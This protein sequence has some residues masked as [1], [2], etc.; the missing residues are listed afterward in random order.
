MVEKYNNF[1][2]HNMK[3][4]FI[5]SL[6]LIG[7]SFYNYLLYHTLVEFISISVGIALF[8]VVFMFKI[9]FENS[10][11]P[12]IAVGYF[13][14]SMVDLLH[15]FAYKGMNILPMAGGSANLATQLWIEARFLQALILV[16][17][18]SLISQNISEKKLLAGLG[19]IFGVIT[20]LVFSGYAPDAYIDTYGLTTFKIVMEYIIIAILCFALFRFYTHRELIGEKTTVILSISIVLT[21]FSE[22]SFTFYISVFGI[23]NLIGHIFKFLAFWFILIEVKD[24]IKS[25]L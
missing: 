22:L 7:V 15:T 4:P 17:A 8:A 18:V 25:K 23:S 11:F 14:V 6:L 10:F 5:I 9:K 1:L 2:L 19:A 21:I 16:A 13:Y 12:F 24:L 20:F 3:I